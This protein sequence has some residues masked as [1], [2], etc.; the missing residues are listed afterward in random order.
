MSEALR[1]AGFDV[2]DAENGPRAVELVRHPPKPFTILV[3]DFHMPGNMDGAEVAAHVRAI[4]P[5][6]P[7]IIISGRPDVMRPSWQTEQGYALLK[8]PF[9]PS[10]LL[11][12]VN[13]MTGRAV[14]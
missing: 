14:H 8:K 4:L 12:L 13:E 11:K 5:G 6:I 7:V 10:A 1:D 9:V 3:T 2:V